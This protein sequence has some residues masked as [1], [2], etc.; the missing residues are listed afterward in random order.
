[1]V[2]ATTATHEQICQTLGK[3]PQALHE[4][5]SLKNY[6]EAFEEDGKKFH[7][8]ALLPLIDGEQEIIKPLKQAGFEVEQL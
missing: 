3:S 7:I 2:I 4:E 5:I 8:F 1:M 6:G